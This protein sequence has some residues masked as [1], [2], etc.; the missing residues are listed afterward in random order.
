MAA[1]K[2]KVTKRRAPKGKTKGSAKTRASKKLA[3]RRVNRKNVLANLVRKPMR[4]LVKRGALLS[5]AI[6][7]KVQKELERKGQFIGPRLPTAK[8]R[9]GMKRQVAAEA[10]ARRIANLAKA[11]DA[12]R[13]ARGTFVGPQ[14]DPEARRQH[15]LLRR[16]GVAGY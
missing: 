5:E 15:D 6:T 12:R 14:N 3:K 16:A 10:K 11:R 4:E 1:R 9:A 2:K 8:E 13:M 7:V